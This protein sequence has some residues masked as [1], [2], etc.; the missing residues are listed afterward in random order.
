M[1]HLDVYDGSTSCA[2]RLQSN[3]TIRPAL[4]AT[5]IVPFPPSICTRRHPPCVSSQLGL[6]Y[7]MA[8]TARS[9]A[10]RPG[11]PSECPGSVGSLSRC[12]TYLA[13]SPG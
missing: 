2:I 9:H 4:G 7:S 3:S 5:S 6:R 8:V 11:S 10:R 13:P 12:V 1:A